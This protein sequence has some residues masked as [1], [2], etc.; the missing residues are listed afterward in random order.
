MSFN[1]KT[2]FKHG[3]QNLETCMLWDM[4]RKRNV[5]LF[6]QLLLLVEKTEAIF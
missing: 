2:Q 1:V 3:N 4:R 6:L 5:F